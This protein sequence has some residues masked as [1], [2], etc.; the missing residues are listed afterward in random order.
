LRVLEDKEEPMQSREAHV[1]TKVRVT[2][3]FSTASLRRKEALRGMPG[4]ITAAWGH[5]DYVA[6]DVLLDDGRS[7]PFWHH[8][9]EEA[10]GGGG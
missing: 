3:S 4:V 6:L 8:E 2:D 9:L 7:E 10:E 5:Q 1:G